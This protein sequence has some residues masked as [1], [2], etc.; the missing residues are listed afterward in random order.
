MYKK[1]Q[2][3]YISRSHGGGIPVAI[4]MKFGPLVHII[5]LINSTKFEHCSFDVPNLARL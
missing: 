1:S 4:S 5:N 3:N 2:K